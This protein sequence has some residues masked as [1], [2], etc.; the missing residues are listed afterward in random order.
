MSDVADYIK[1]QWDDIH[2][3]RNQDWRIL[4]IIGAI[5]I[6]LIAKADILTDYQI[7]IIV[8]ALIISF[9][10]FYVSITHFIIFRS[11]MGKIAAC[12]KKLE[13]ADKD[14]DFDFKFKYGRFAVQQMIMIIYVLII[15]ILLTW[16]IKITTT[17]SLWDA[18]KIPVFVFILGTFLCLFKKASIL[19]K[20][21]EKPDKNDKNKK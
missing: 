15:S 21:L 20:L 9:I 11:K 10:G 6:A 12:E 8:V 18:V 4:Q 13:F 1:T 7:A 19:R 16:L 3:S 2:H 5:F 17:G 14:P